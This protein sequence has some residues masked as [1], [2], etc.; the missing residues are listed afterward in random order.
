MQR[1]LPKTRKSVETTLAQK[2]AHW[3]TSRS[4]LKAPTA[5]QI[6]SHVCPTCIGVCTRAGCACVPVC[7]SWTL[8]RTDFEGRFR[9]KPAWGVAR[10]PTFCTLPFFS[11]SRL[12][13]SLRATLIHSVLFSRLRRAG[14]GRI[15]KRERER[16][17]ERKS[18]LRRAVGL[19]K[20]YHLSIVV[21]VVHSRSPFNRRNFSLVSFPSWTHTPPPTNLTRCTNR[22][23]EDSVNL[24]CRSVSSMR[25]FFFFLLYLL[26][27]LFQR[28]W[29]HEIGSRTAIFLCFRSFKEIV[30]IRDGSGFRSLRV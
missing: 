18:G 26:F 19:H 27:Q 21:T 4:R 15:R 25:F 28:S 20:R 23:F 17:R 1:P 6:Q 14:R 9:Y 30:S 13:F 7:T 2:E 3:T 8:P 29:L 12:L 5:T 24:R 16:R 10:S 22:L 11:P